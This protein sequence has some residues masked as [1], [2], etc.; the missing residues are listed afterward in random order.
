MAAPGIDSEGFRP[1]RDKTRAWAAVVRLRPGTKFHP[2]LDRAKRSSSYA[3]TNSGSSSHA[4]PN[5]RE[6]SSGGVLAD[7]DLAL[8]GVVGLADDAFLLHPLDQ[9]GGAV[10]ADRQAALDVAGGG[11]A[12]AQHDGDGLVVEVVRIPRGRRP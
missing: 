1:I 10:V 7:Q 11:L 4:R 8:S 12:V 9:R 3:D 5:E 2:R 6:L